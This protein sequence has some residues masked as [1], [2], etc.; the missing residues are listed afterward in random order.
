MTTAQ[1]ASFPFHLSDLV[2]WVVKTKSGMTIKYSVKPAT[3][4]QGKEGGRR[5]AVVTTYPSTSLSAYCK[6]DSP[7]HPTFEVK[8]GE[9]P[10]L[11]LRIADGVGAKDAFK[12]GIEDLIMDCGDVLWESEIKGCLGGDQEL[13][14]ALSKYA[15]T[16]STRVLKVKW[17]DRQ[18]PDVDPN[19]WP[20][21]AEL[22]KEE[23]RKMF[24]QTGTPFRVLANCQGGHGRSGTAVVCLMMALSDY[25][26]LD[27]ITHLRAIHCARAIESKAQHDYINTVGALLGRVENA[28]EA[29][30]VKSYKDRFLSLVCGTSKVYRERLEGKK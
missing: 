3:A 30:G 21:L 24:A 12:K 15:G 29:E 5:Q 19:F 25:S 11:H 16:A 20:A 13:V 10:I 6:H 27:A 7:L 22:L 14:A 2:C 1:T 23:G 18:E 9:N 28:H 17:A 26:P 8:E 4:L